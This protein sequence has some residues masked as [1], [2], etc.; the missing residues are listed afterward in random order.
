MDEKTLRKKLGDKKYEEIHKHVQKLKAAGKSPDDIAE[1]VRTKF[2]EAARHAL[3]D[4]FSAVWV[5]V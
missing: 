5:M 3:V 4:S 1:E 2:P